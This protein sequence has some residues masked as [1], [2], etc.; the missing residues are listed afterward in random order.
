MSRSLSLAPPSSRAPS[1]FT[2]EEGLWFGD[3]DD[4]GAR[5]AARASMAAMAGRVMGAR[6]FPEAAQ[7]L[8]QL[9]REDD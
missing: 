8:V 6:P 1:A 5:E 9:T 7:K 4:E 2:L 3:F